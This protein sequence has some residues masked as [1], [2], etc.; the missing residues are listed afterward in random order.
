MQG[1][2]LFVGNLS[3]SVTTEE[4][5]ELFSTYGE[6][7][8]A[9]VVEGKGFGFVEMSSQVQAEGAKAAL[10][11]NIDKF[12]SEG[13]ILLPRPMFEALHLPIEKTFR[14]PEWRELAPGH[15]AACHFA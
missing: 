11:G 12:Q 2:K 10:N 9:K 15:Y 8:E 13:G 4:L 1:S 14:V 6:V 3:H 5:N 7:K